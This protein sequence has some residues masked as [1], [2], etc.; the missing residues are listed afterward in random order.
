MVLK[1]A[2]PPTDVASYRPISLLPMISKILEKLLLHRLNN[3]IL[4]RLATGAS[5]W[6]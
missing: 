2:K 1:P 3:E 4:S 6:I 5:V